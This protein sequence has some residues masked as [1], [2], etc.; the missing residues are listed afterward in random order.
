MKTAVFLLVTFCLITISIGAQ[1]KRVARKG[2]D[3]RLVKGK[4]SVYITFER[5]G[6]RE[7]LEPGESR[8]GI[9]LRFHNNTKW[10]ISFR[11]FGVPRELGEV[12][13]YYEI[14]ELPQS[15]LERGSHSSTEAKEE[16]KRKSEIPIGYLPGDSFDVISIES[17][18]SI[19]FSVPSDH[20]AE[21]LYLRIAF[22]YGWEDH[23]DVTAGREAYHYITFSSSE[24]PRRQK[25]R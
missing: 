19:L 23:N 15:P 11:A 2:A 6:E 21:G 12:G 20:L 22:N 17:G 25:N 24:L 1:Q 14:E 8:E 16:I 18:D 5:F 13:M 3:V 10:P 7:P 9:W 4:P